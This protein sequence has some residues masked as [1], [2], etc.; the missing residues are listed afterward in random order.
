MS[1]HATHDQNKESRQL[2]YRPAFLSDN[3]F[4]KFWHQDPDV[5]YVVFLKV[6]TYKWRK[7]RHAHLETLQP[8]KKLGP[9]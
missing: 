9:F 7:L 1:A 3:Q 4:V 2:G 8:D 5:S 6:D